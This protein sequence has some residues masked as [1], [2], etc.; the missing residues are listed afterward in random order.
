MAVATRHAKE[1]ARRRT[2][3]YGENIFRV[4]RSGGRHIRRRSRSLVKYPGYVGR[5]KQLAATANLADPISGRADGDYFALSRHTHG[6]VVVAYPHTDKDCPGGVG[7]PTPSAAAN[8]T[9]ILSVSIA[10]SQ[11]MDRQLV[12]TLDRESLGFQF[13]R[14]SD[15][16]LYI[17]ITLCRAAP[18]GGL[19]RSRPWCR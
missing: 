13:P 15:R 5:A 8:R 6:L 11:W 10:R 3:Q 17:F 12:D 19:R 1:N 18:T 4:Q 16:F 14:S 2:R 9:G 7:G